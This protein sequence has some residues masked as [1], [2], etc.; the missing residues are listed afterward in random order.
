MPNLFLATLG[1][2]PEAITTAYDRLCERYRFDKI[3][4]LTTDRKASGIADAAAALDQ[5]CRRD[6]PDV[7]LIWHTLSDG[8]TP[9]I[10]IT[11]S[12]TAWAYFRAIFAALTPWKQDR[13][14]LHF[15]ISGGRKAMSLYAALAAALVFGGDDRLWTVLSPPSILERGD[16][17]P[18][19]GLRDQVQVVELPLMPARMIPGSVEADALNL[20]AV[21]AERGKVRKDFLA[22]LTKREREVVEALVKHPHTRNER[23]ADMLHKSPRTVESQL[24]SAYSKLASYVDF[25]DL[26]ADKRQALIDFLRDGE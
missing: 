26:I 10:D 13:Y 8:D 24:A 14:T 21:I 11:D 6:Y 23:L 18:L 7:P 1:Q 3:I 12:E 25:G 20:D 5:V 4:V 2:R 17:H 9:L 15:L 16:F 22:L 19:P